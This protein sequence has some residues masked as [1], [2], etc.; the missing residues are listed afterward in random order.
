MLL[1]EG[2]AALRP[3]MLLK[4]LL[5]PC[6]KPS[7]VIPSKSVASAL[8]PARP[9]QLLGGCPTQGAFRPG[10]PLYGLPWHAREPPGSDR[11]RHPPSPAESNPSPCADQQPQAGNPRPRSSASIPS[12]APTGSRPLRSYL[13]ELDAHAATLRTQDAVKQAQRRLS[14]TGAL[15]STTRCFTR[16][17]VLDPWSR[18]WQPHLTHGA[19]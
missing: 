8:P 1:S 6:G 18:R 14:V 4:S 11:R 12:L 15:R 3:F 7:Q 5:R 2:T 16:W 19:G 9:R 13:A 17:P 10:W